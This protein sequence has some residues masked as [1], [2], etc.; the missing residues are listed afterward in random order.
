[1]YSARVDLRELFSF[2]WDRLDRRMDGLTDAEWLWCPTAD[3]RIS[4]RWRLEHITAFLSEPRNWQWLGLEPP[5]VESGP[6]P[7]SAADA[8]MAADR[9]FVAWQELLSKPD[10]EL[11]APIG[12]PAGP[13]G[14]ATR[15]SFVLHLADE[16]IHHGAEAALLRDLYAARGQRS[17]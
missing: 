2:V 15:R 8:L 13:Y 17:S 1:V 10:I 9:A 7:S 14:Q 11:T 4:L 3:D 12:A 6:A 5:A 16:L